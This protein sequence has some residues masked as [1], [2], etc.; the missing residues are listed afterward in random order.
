MADPVVRTDCPNCGAQLTPVTGPG[1]DTPP[2]V[3]HLCRLGWWCAELTADAR[4]AWQSCTQ[5][6]RWDALAGIQAAIVL[7]RQ[8]SGS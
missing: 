2:W 4:E 6:F 8:G 5:T 1:G 3:C 7:E